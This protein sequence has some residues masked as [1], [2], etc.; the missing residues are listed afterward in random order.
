M[1]TEEKLNLIYEIRESRQKDRVFEL[2]EMLKNES[3]DIV[4]ESLVE[5]LKILKNEDAIEK[6]MEFFYSEDLYLKNAAVT[7]L[8]E[9]GELSIPYLMKK[10][11]DENE[12]V[13]KLAIDTI[14]MIRNPITVDIL[15]KG[16]EDKSINNL[17]SVIEYIADL[18]GYHY[19]NKIAEIL[20]ESRDPFLTITC[21][22]AL[23]EIGDEYSLE[24]VKKKFPDPSKID[25]FTL[26]AYMRFLASHATVEFL[27]FVIEV[28]NE[29]S[30]IFY[31]ELIDI[32]ER[33]VN[34]KNE[35]SDSDVEKVYS[36]LLKLLNTSIPSMNKYEV[37]GLIVELRGESA[38][39]LILE[40]LDS[41][42][43]FI[44]MGA[45]EAVGKLFK[46][47]RE[48]IEKLKNF[49]KREVNEEL[50][51]VARDILEIL[52]R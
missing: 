40:M 48:I 27:P 9:Y 10:L 14:H 46:G 39:D 8:A 18:E 1:T 2:I 19:S 41:N 12:H 11:D 37:F 50:K 17:I 3:E 24:V 43:F 36:A 15:A 7:I 45:L 51:M 33:F 49:L 6:L 23:S 22:E 13:R 4:K 26:P 31:K 44:K 42:D 25:D 38:K 52:D 5:A 32:L 30:E 21:L 47:N 35:L 16:L 29:K 28:L 20:E 34:M